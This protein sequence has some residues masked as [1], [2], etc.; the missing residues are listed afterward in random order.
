MNKPSVFLALLAIPFTATAEVVI[1]CD[2][3]VGPTMRV[4]VIREAPIAD[5]HVYFL[6][7][8][9]KATP[10]FSDAESREGRLYVPPAPE[11]RI[12]RLFSP[13][14]S[15]LTQFKASS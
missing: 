8:N 15:Q 9:G 7:Q 5:T 2:I 1:A 13:G 11:R 3:G 12:V 6:R 4:E 14:N 10:I